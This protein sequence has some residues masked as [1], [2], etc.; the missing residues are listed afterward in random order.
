M[1]KTVFERIYGQ[2]TDRKEN[3]VGCNACVQRC[4][5]QCISMKQDD[6]GFLYPVTDMDRCIDCRLCSAVCPVIHQGHPRKPQDT[7]AACASD[8]SLVRGSSSGGLFSVL[9]SVVINRG[10][11]V[12]GA[13]F[14]PDWSVVHDCAENDEELEALRGSKYV[15]SNIGDSFP[16]V[17]KFLKD[18]REVLFV[19]TPCQIAGLKRFLR[20]D[21]TCLTTID[22]VCH[23]VPSPRVWQ[24]YLAT[25]SDDPASVIKTISFRDKRSGWEKY[26]LS[27]GLCPKGKAE[28]KDLYERIW[29][30]LYMKLFLRNIS[31]RPSCFDCPAREGKSESDITIGDFWGL[32]N[33]HPDFYTDKGCTLVLCNSGRGVELWSAAADD[34][35]VLKSDYE[36]AVRYNSSLIKSAAKPAESYDVFWKNY[37]DEGLV[38]ASR[39]IEP[40]FRVSLIDRVKGHLKVLL[41]RL[42]IR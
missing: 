35:K 20:K 39:S 27:M 3:C 19:G 4:P 8:A 5:E 17:E 16:K 1:S 25:L 26:G 12:F 41:H 6:Q 37:Y 36:A 14:A 32:K 24:D 33:I 28:C 18:K 31:L 9:A 7:Y 42:N 11:V 10:G 22:L 13:R 38:S 15:Q 30:N 23:G 40:Y 29:S 21:Y 2:G 34:C